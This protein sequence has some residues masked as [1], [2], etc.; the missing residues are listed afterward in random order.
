MIPFINNIGDIW[1]SYLSSGLLNN[2]LFLGITLIT[3][4][5]LKNTLAHI[6]YNIALLGLI[7]LM[8]PPFI[9]LA[10]LPSNIQIPLT[11]DIIPAEAIE[12]T[13]QSIAI[14]P[15]LDS[16]GMLFLIW[17]FIVVIFF[18]I[19][20]ARTV[21]LLISIKNSSLIKELQINNCRVRL[22]TTQKIYIPMTISIFSPRIY[23]PKEWEDWSV[24]SQTMILNHELA[25]I[26]RHDNIIQLVQI[27]IQGIYFFHPL[28]WI[29]NNNMNKYREMACDDMSINGDRRASLLF[30][31]Y[32]V[33]IAE[34]MVRSSLTSQSVSAL[35]RQNDNL[36]KRVKYMME[37]KTMQPKTKK[38]VRFIVCVLC[39]LILLLSLKLTQANPKIAGDIQ[40][41]TVKIKINAQ[42]DYELDGQKVTINELNKKLN[43]FASAEK[44]PIVQLQVGNDIPMATVL[45]VQS[46]LREMGLTK[47]GY[48][49]PSG[50]ITHLVLPPI[51][52]ENVVEKI[53]KKDLSLIFINNDGS[54]MVDDESMT[55]QKMA[56][57]IKKL[58]KL[59]PV[60]IV[61]ITPSKQVIFKNYLDVL[62]TVKKA[63]AKRISIDG[64]K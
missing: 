4:F 10:I 12:T 31:R 56:D 61:D 28:V 63:G 47:I 41:S 23:V 27:L 58:L 30:S 7:K 59:N 13:E 1:M 62:M 14:A 36:L 46:I 2:T 9:S 51:G 38:K 48:F 18:M 45:N 8:I 57:Y 64:Q 52:E 16:N 39:S 29:L 19:V 22:Y 20:A 42:Q 25:H 50:E 37:D 35:I 49:I 53:P 26:K 60:L 44:Q 3:M 55:L 21:R 5:L 43:D 32:L 6:R 40:R 34:N 24:D 15:S 33:K 54:L 17:M 11:L